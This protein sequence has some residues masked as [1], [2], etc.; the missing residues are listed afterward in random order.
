[1]RP[2][3]AGSPTCGTR[4]S[5]TSSGGRTTFATR[6]RQATNER[7][8]RL[9]AGRAD[10]I[11]CVS[12]AI[13]DEM[14]AL[15]ARGPV[16]TIANGCDFDDFAGLEFRPATRFRITHTGSFFGKRDPRPFLQALQDSQ[17]DVVAR[18]VGDFRSVD[19]EWAATLDLGDRLELIPYAP[20]ADRSGSSAI[21]RRCSPRARTPAE[22]ERVCSRGRCSSISPP[23]GRFSLSCRPTVPRLGSSARPGAGVVVAPDDVAGMRDALEQ[24]HARHLNGGLPAI[25][26][27]DDVRGSLSRQARV[28]ETAALLREVAA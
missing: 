9:V 16:R 5:R 3:S 17:L 14:R 19:R 2:A 6:A 23:A 1:M 15:G 13:A 4:S 28:E 20:R 12:D 11:S 26:L 22:G 27:P 10:A 25:E 8:A 7:L 18:F 21:R 24:L